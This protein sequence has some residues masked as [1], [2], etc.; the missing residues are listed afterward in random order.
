MFGLNKKYCQGF[1]LKTLMGFNIL[2]IVCFVPKGVK[3]QYV[4]GDIKVKK[5]DQ[6]FDENNNIWLKK[7]NYGNYIFNGESSELWISHPLSRLFE[8]KKESRINLISDKIDKKKF[9]KMSS[10]FNNSFGA[11]IVSN[12]DDP[13]VIPEKNIEARQWNIRKD[14]NIYILLLGKKEKFCF[15]IIKKLGSS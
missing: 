12:I 15:L 3:A 6:L 14:Q 5:I 10:S 2:L 13:F 4:F 1:K 7:D 8:N 9:K 11:S